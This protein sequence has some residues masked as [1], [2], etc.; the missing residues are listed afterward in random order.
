MF[1]SVTFL[2]G[3][4]FLFGAGEEISWGQRIF[5][6]ESSEFFLKNNAQQETNLHNLVVGGV[7]INK[8]VFGKGIA[9]FIVLYLVV[10]PIIW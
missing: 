4:V 2:C 7:K 3:L 10:F 5:N 1:L 9:I 8:L 6:T